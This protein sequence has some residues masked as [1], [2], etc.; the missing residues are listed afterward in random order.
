MPIRFTCVCGRMPAG[1]Q[2]T[3]TS[4]CS[5]PGTACSRDILDPVR[6]C[7][8]RCSRPLSRSIALPFKSSATELGPPSQRRRSQRAPAFRGGLRASSLSTSR[9]IQ[10]ALSSSEFANCSAVRT[11]AARNLE[12][13]FRSCGCGYRGGS[14]MLTE[15]IATPAPTARPRPSPGARS[16][17]GAA[18][19]RRSLAARRS[20]RR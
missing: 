18:T 19:C 20:A 1:N 3:F 10:L 12:F 17:A 5:P 6:H 15:T 16:Y 4:S 14:R 7:K 13:R 11:A 9:P 2:S 8:W